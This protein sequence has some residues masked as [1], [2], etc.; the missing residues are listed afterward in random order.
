VLETF[1]E[2]L[3]LTYRQL[4]SKHQFAEKFGV[5]EEDFLK[6]VL[7]NLGSSSP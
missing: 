3:R 2:L 4:D 7:Q 5:S 6:G 1:R